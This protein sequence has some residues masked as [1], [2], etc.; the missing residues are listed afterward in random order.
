MCLH[1]N[2]EL[3]YYLFIAPLPNMCLT[4]ACIQSGKTIHFNNYDFVKN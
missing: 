3:I 4:P 1:Y 2:I